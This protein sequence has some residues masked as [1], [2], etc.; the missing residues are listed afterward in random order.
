MNEEQTNKET[1]RCCDNCGNLRCARSIVAYWWDECV[2]S[3]FTKH[4]RPKEDK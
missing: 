4:W 3:D 2:D 1:R